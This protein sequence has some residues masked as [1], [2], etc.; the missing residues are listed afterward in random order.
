LFWDKNQKDK[1]IKDFE[2]R[3][4]LGGGEPWRET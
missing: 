3:E 1:K 4:T 2:A